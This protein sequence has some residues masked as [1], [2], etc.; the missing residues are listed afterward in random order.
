[1]EE[2]KKADESER[3]AKVLARAGICSR[4]DAEK[5]VAEGRVM[6]NGKKLD[7]PAF[8]VPPGGPKTEV[9][10]FAAATALRDALEPRIKIYAAL[11][12]PA[13]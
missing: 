1:M 2:N 3:I 7:T 9:Q 10:Y 4:R 5:L 8:K 6:V 13:K 12:E 11:F